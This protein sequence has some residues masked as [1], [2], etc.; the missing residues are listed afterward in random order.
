MV[1][2]MPL[3]Y[4][5]VEPRDG[6]GDELEL[7]QLGVMAEREA[8]DGGLIALLDGADGPFNFGNM[9]ICGAMLRWMSSSARSGLCCHA[10]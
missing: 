1:V 7:K 6:L 4:E 8:T 10:S 3:A 9:F 2:E 5:H